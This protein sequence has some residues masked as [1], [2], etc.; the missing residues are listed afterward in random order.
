MDERDEKIA[1][2]AAEIEFLRAEIAEL[3]RRLGLNSGN[4]SKPPS[5]DGLGKKPSPVS[6]RRLGQKPSG[7]QVGHGGKTLEFRAESEVDVIEEHY[8]QGCL[9]GMDLGA[10]LPEAGFE[11]RQ[12]W[13]IPMPKVQVTEHQ[14]YRKICPHCGVCSK[15]ASPDAVP[16][17]VSYGG[18]I[19][20][21]AVY[22]Q[23]GQFIPEDRLAGVFG[24]IF[25]LKIRPATLVSYGEKLAGMLGNWWES[26]R[27][28]IADAPVKHADETG[29]RIG[30]KTSW[31]HVLSTEKATVYRP[32]A[33]RGE[34]FTG[35]SGTVVHDHFKPYYALEKV[36]HALCNAHHLREL[37]AC[38]EAKEPWA[39]RMHRHLLLL[40]RLVKNPVSAHTKAR[41]VQVYDAIL[42]RG[43]AYHEALPPFCKTAPKRGRTAKHPS[44]NLLIR[45][46]DFKEDVLRCLFD[47][48]VP[49]TNNLA[50]RDIR[51]MKV[52]QKI[53]GGFRSMHG[54][55]TFAIL[56]SF[57]STARK[58]NH[59]LLTA[60]T[61]ALGAQPPPI[62][63]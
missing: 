28:A 63:A 18:N 4:S 50:E 27:A 45:L 41:F 15:A 2:Q 43:F 46:R 59:N 9:C 14:L 62:L 1:A 13:D 10:V 33:K 47:E 48:A 55:H 16:P 8:P 3:K 17:G 51:M 36:T 6:L 7:G 24:D 20:G 58:Q 42:Q 34:I 56:R 25:G 21:W 44:H 35:L 54:A 39:A 22:L 61:A 30:G 53:S 31:L 57:L 38:I 12:V 49:F 26:T 60:I 23:H 52:K 29:F 5:S 37:N 40:S 32:S 11:R 19:Q